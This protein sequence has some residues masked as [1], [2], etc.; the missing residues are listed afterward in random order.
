MSDPQMREFSGRLRRI[1]KIHRR[2]GG[3]EAAG[4][5]GQSHYTRLRLRNERR[6]LLRPLV[7]FV[8]VITL[9]KGA[10]LA[11]IGQ[12]AYTGT[13]VNLAEGGLVDQIG[14]FIMSI[15][16]VTLTLAQIAAPFFG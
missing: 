15:D 13:L 14:G 5:L 16:P 2:G 9:F 12:T 11:A 1:D 3:F 10:L 8:S 4:T 7:I 6:P